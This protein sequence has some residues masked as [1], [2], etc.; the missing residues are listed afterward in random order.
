[1]DPLDPN[2]PGQEGTGS[3]GDGLTDDKSSSGGSKL[4]DTATMIWTAGLAGVGSILAGIAAR[5]FGRRQ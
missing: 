1:T 5:L 2:D 4:P 3:D